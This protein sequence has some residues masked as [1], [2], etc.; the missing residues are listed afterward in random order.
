M[1]RRK[2]IAKFLCGAEAFHSLVHTY[3]WLSGTTT[4]GLSHHS[5]A[6]LECRRCRRTRGDLA[7][8]GTLRIEASR[9]GVQ[10]SIVRAITGSSERSLA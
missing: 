3:F 6:T 8:P 1:N 2:E 5:N 9:F 7:R 4:E 10:M